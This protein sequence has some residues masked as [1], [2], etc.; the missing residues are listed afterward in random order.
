LR[1]I[2]DKIYE[3][4]EARSLYARSLMIQMNHTQA[5]T[6]KLAGLLTPYRSEDAGCP[7][8]VV[9]SNP[10]ASGELMLPKQWGVRLDDGLLGSLKEWLGDKSVKIMW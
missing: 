9:Y 3:L 7:V 6:A 5:D 8:R 4:G 10:Q 2:A 1:I